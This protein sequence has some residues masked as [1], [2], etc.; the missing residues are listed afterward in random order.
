MLFAHHLALPWGLWQIVTRLGEAQLMLPT[1]LALVMWLAWIGARRT[2]ILWMALLSLAVGLTTASK[3]A[4]IGWGLGIPGLNF[5]GISG[6]AMHAAAGFPLLLRCLTASNGRPTHRIAVGL[7]YAVAALVT[8][9]RV[10]IGAHSMSESVAGFA[11]GGV[12]SAL[13]L[14]FGTVPQ[15]HLPRWLLAALVVAQL[16]NPAAAPTLPTH[17]MVTQ[18]A[19]WMSGHER[20]YT[21]GMMLKRERERQKALPSVT[22]QWQLQRLRAAMPRSTLSSGRRIPKVRGKQRR[23]PS[24][25]VGLPLH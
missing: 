14:S 9:S 15:Q 3:I 5:T 19:L 21:R 7:G 18:V 20:P 22:A 11:L 16:L 8:V 24:L 6:H 1:G 2:A 12:A 17:D 10:V 13:A 25:L 4:F 23:L